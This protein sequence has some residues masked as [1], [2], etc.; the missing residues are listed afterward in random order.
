MEGKLGWVVRRVAQAVAITVAAIVFI[1]VFGWVVML[2]W[3]YVVPPVFHGPAI[4]YGQAF[5]LLVLCRIL[6]G[7]LRGW[8]GAHGRWR[9]HAWRE[10]WESMTPE[11]RSRLRE[12][13]MQ[14][15]GRGLGAP[16]EDQGA[17]S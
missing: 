2:L 1:A 16:P 10:R 7:G 6:F 11:E 3:N 4:G 13:F 8:R 12:R 15:C 17:H 5:A 9:R 14:R